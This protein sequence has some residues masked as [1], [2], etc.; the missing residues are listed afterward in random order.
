MLQFT[1]V[2]EY[3]DPNY[4]NIY[5]EE[6]MVPIEPISFQGKFGELYHV[7]VTGNKVNGYHAGV[8]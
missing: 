6:Y 4:D 3:F 5:P 8:N 7:I 1:I 2:T